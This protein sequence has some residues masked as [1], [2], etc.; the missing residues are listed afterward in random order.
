[1]RQVQAALDK[2]RGR[3][4]TAVHTSCATGEGQPRAKLRTRMGDRGDRTGEGEE[5][6]V[7]A[8]NCTSC[9]GISVQCTRARARSLGARARTRN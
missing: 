7:P 6:N 2:E 3:D 4:H 9:K 1:M 5:K 8:S